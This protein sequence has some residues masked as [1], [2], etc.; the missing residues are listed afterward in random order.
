V[1]LG[2]WRKGGGC[3]LDAEEGGLFL[4]RFVCVFFFF[5]FFL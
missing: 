2:T 1:W 4:A 3:V 5:S